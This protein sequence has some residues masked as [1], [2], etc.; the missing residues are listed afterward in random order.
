VTASK[1]TPSEF[2][3]TNIEWQKSSYTGGAGNCVEMA[4]VGEYILMRDSKNPDR[5]PHV[6][7]RA[8]ISAYFAGVKDGEFDH[9]IGG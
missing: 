8:E 9:V 7:T 5:E 4:A 2:D 1:P 6:F 3:L